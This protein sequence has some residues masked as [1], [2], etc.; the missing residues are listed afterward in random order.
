MKYRLR[1]LEPKNIDLNIDFEYDKLI[2]IDN[3]LIINAPTVMLTPKFVVS[4]SKVFK[5]LFPEKLLLCL[6]KGVEIMELE[7]IEEEQ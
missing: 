5:E 1:V 3:V 4:F 2:K 6:P 7:V